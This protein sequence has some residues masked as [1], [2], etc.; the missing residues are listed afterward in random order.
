MKAVTRSLRL[1]RADQPITYELERKSV[2][3]YNLRVRRDGTIHLSVP[4]STTVAAVEAFLIER[5]EWLI[6]ALAKV[7]ERAEAH[8]SAET[9]TDSLPYL[10]GTLAVLWCEGSPAQV[11]ADLENR[12]LTITLPDTTAPE[13]RAAAIERFEK[14]ETFRLVS[15][16]LECYFP[17]FEARGVSR[18]ASLR[19]KR[20]T[21][22]FGSCA[23]QNRSLNFASRLCEYPLPFVEYVVVHELC[24][25]LEANHS[26]RFWAEVER[27]LP[28]Y[29]E[30][31]RLAKHS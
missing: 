3:N 20:L 4:R 9:V 27:I 5:E 8:P 15:T 11:E 14:N 22:R 28:D 25:F 2:K 1:P 21:S 12:R 30:R 13:Y 26:P 16:L 10:G 17:L 29:A 24:H 18:P 6:R 31:A 7:E 23:P 19:V